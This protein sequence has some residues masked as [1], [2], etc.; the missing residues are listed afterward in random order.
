MTPTSAYTGLGW[1]LF[2]VLITA[3]LVVALVALVLSTHGR[4]SRPR[5]GARHAT[6][7]PGAHRHGRRA[8]RPPLGGPPWGKG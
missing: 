7:T 4:P 3:L 8:A 6:H 5:S 1:T 2:A